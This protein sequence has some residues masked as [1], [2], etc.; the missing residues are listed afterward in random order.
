LAKVEQQAIAMNDTDWPFADPPNVATFTVRQIIEG[1][2]PILWVSH[3]DEDGAWQ[4]HTGGDAE[5]GDAMIICLKNIVAR[6]PSV[7][8]LADLPCGWNAW[9]ESPLHPWTRGPANG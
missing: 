5:I 1:G 7:L 2:Q 8:E 3:D 9:R 4:F 6:D